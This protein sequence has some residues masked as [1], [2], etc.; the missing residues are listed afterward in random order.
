MLQYKIPQDVQREDTII[1]PI[2]M[3]QLIICAIGG[4]I[5]YTLYMILSKSYY[6]SVWLPPIAIISLL[7]VAFA[8]IEIRGISFTKWILL[9]LETI[10]L[11]N[12]RVW[13]KR[14]S[15]QFLFRFPSPSVSKKENE[16]EDENTKEV[17]IDHLEEISKALDFS[18]GVLDEQKDSPTAN[19]ED[20]YLAATALHEDDKMRHDAR[21]Q[22]FQE[23]QKISA[24]RGNQAPLRSGQVNTLQNPKKA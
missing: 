19:A 9:M 8:F 15:T 10:I 5:A 1:G 23:D 20:H 4:G 7:T 24:I 18:S 2:T 14:Q 13:D 12:K 11:P 17:S 3:R 21:L 6:M 22:Q 16:D